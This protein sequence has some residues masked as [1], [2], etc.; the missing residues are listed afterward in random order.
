[1]KTIGLDIGTTTVCGV[2]VDAETGRMLASR[3]LPNDAALPGSQPWERLQSPARLETLCRSLVDAWA[4]EYP[5]VA[6]IGISNQMHGMLYLD[7]HGEAVSPLATWQDERGNRPLETGVSYAARLSALTGYPMA[8]GYGFC[9]HWHHLQNGTVPA[10]AAKLCT[11]G[12]YIALRLTGETAP[13][14]HATNAAGFGLYDLRT[15]GFDR[16]MLKAAGIAESWLPAVETAPVCAGKTPLGQTV[17]VAIGDNQAGFFGSGSGEGAVLVNIGT[18]GQVSMLADTAET[19]PDIDARP[20]L[21]GRMLAVGCSLCGGEAY[22]ALK[23]FFQRAADLMNVKPGPLYAAMNAAAEALYDAPGRLNGLRVD[24]RLCGTRA[25]ASLR[26]SVQGLGLDTFTPE[27]L[28]LG[29]L[30]GICDELLGYWRAM[31]AHAEARRLVGSGNGLRK[32]LLLRRIV[33]EAFG[34]PMQVPLYEEEA[35]YGVALLSLHTLGLY[36][37]PQDAQALIPYQ[38]AEG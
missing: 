2:L 17:T 11:I 6:G 28:T 20:Y 9:T 21:G 33:S 7:A 8:T 36:A 5:D 12:D 4:D 31:P 15:G 19:G 1:M 27:H 10:G 14:M 23:R 25:D 26:A 35:A 22:A 34:M 3:T 38:N 29:V 37:A 30:C 32:N 24:T 13:R 16:P 18:S